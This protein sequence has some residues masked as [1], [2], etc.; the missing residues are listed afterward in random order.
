[1]EDPTRRFEN[2]V[3]H[4]IRYRPRYPQA[5]LHFL[6]QELNLVPSSVIADI[7]SG[8]GISS[9]LFLSAGNVVFGVEPNT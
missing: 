6:K 4:Y 5:V 2:R 8:T 3:E 9:E 1:M 7:G